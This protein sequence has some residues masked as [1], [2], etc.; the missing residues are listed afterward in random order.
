[1]SK[2]TTKST[3][4]NEL[5]GE[6]PDAQGAEAKPTSDGAGAGE[7]VGV[8]CWSDIKRRWAVIDGW[9]IRRIDDGHRADLFH[10]LSAVAAAAP[11]NEPILDRFLADL[12]SPSRVLMSGPQKVRAATRELRRWLAQPGYR[13]HLREPKGDPD[14]QAMVGIV[15][16]AEG[17]M[18][19]PE[20]FSEF[21]RSVR[22]DASLSAFKKN[23]A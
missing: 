12:S 16:A 22:D 23:S 21:C 5:R 4:E 1:M 8:D 18:S 11:E 2:P 7:I 10:L 15:K 13:P 9:G 19:M 17:P 3:A 6:Q 20:M 14:I